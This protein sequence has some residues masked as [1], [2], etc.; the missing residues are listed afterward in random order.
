MIEGH[1]QHAEQIMFGGE[2]NDSY[3]STKIT[4]YKVLKGNIDAQE[5]ELIDPN[6]SFRHG[7]SE[8]GMGKAIG[9]FMLYPSEIKASPR[10]EI[11]TEYKFKYKIAPR[12][13]CNVVNYNATDN[14]GIENYL[15]SPYGIY[16]EKDIEKKV[17]RTVEQITARKYIEMSPLPKKAIGGDLINAKS[18]NSQAVTIST[19]SPDTLRACIFT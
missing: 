15:E 16:N 19:I 8:G 10:T 9:V 7:C 17:Y 5:V 13:G 4:V 6:I 1:L 14:K 2:Y 18:E 12:V 3:S 11:G